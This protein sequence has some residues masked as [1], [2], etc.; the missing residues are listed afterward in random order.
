MPAAF[1]FSVQPGIDDA[2]RF[3]FADHPLA[4]GNNIR[5]VVLFSE[6][7]ALLVPANGATN[8][9]DFV[10]HD[11]LA[12]PAASENDPQIGFPIRH[13]LGRRPDKI[14][15]VD[16]R[17]A[18][19]PKVENLAPRRPQVRRDDPLVTKSRMIR[20]NGNSHIRLRQRNESPDNTIIALTPNL[21]SENTTSG[22]AL[23][24]QTNPIANANQKVPTLFCSIGYMYIFEKPNR[25]RFAEYM[26]LRPPPSPT[27]YTLLARHSLDDGGFPMSKNGAYHTCVGAPRQVKYINYRLSPRIRSRQ[28][29]EPPTRRP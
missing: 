19:R 7:C 1:K 4:E 24:S 26:F 15:V 29:R 22:S 20:C 28:L 21:A 18:V 25:V 12:I 2:D 27:N 6:P 9:F 13:T 23:S 10:G 11:R 3:L 16:R 14:R 17:F 8:P 5:V